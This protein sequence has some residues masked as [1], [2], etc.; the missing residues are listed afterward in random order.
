MPPFSP[1]DPLARHLRH[2]LPLRTL[3]RTSVTL[4]LH[5]TPVS[6]QNVSVG[7]RGGLFPALYSCGRLAKYYEK[8]MSEKKSEDALEAA[9]VLK[10]T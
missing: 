1:H 6:I 4:D 8:E 5:V 9:A 7:A 10:E 3:S 2:T